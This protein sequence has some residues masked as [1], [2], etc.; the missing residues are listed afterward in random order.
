MSIKTKA[1]LNRLLITPALIIAL[2]IVGS[3]SVAS[4]SKCNDIDLSEYGGEITITGIVGIRVMQHNDDLTWSP[5]NDTTATPAESLRIL[6]EMDHVR[7]Q[8]SSSAADQQLEKMPWQQLI[9]SLRS[10][11][12]NSLMSTAYACEPANSATL[13]TRIVGM[14]LIS[15]ANYRD[16]E[17]GE[18]LRNEF[19]VSMTP[20]N[21]IDPDNSVLWYRPVSI[22]TILSVSSS[23]PKPAV[24]YRFEP[25]VR[26]SQTNDDRT[27]EL[28]QFTFSIE[29]N[30]GELFS[31]TSAPVLV[32]I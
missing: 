30:N 26:E 27:T 22:G 5:T 17:A 14:D 31:V 29:L 1:L 4:E 21:G 7:Q 6:I 12:F 16:K 32:A 23:A 9:G 10:N 15:S 3:L 28:H 11:V 20:F 8:K 19:S 2:L 25:T 13:Q 18:S 24:R